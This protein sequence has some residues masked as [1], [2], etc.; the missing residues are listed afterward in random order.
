MRA[1]VMMALLGLGFLAAWVNRD[2]LLALS[3]PAEAAA[4]SAVPPPAAPQPNLLTYKA[5]RSGHVYVAASINGSE[6]RML[7][8]T[9]ATLIALRVEDAR[10]AGFSLASLRYDGHVNTANGAAR[11]AH[12]KLREVRLGQLAFENVDAV[13]IDAALPVSLLGMSFLRR[14]DGYEMRDGQL[15][16]TW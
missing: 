1:I 8:D 14:L 12:V 2:A 4:P 13:V 11:A 9:G 15:V 6:T 16:I 3:E 7:V 10:S 5:D